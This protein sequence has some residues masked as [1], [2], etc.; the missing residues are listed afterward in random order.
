MKKTGNRLL[1]VLSM[2]LMIVSMIGAS[3]VQSS[4]GRVSVSDVKWINSE[5]KAMTGILLKPDTATAQSPAP[6]I[7]CCHGFLN[8]KE[9][10][11]IN[12]VE[13]ARRGYVVLACDMPSHGNSDIG[14][15]PG[16]MLNSV[17]EAVEFLC[18]INYVDD[19]RIGVTG[20]SFG[21]FSCHMAALLDG[22][23]DGKQHIAAILFNSMD[24]VYVDQTTGL[25]ANLYGSRNVGIIA[26]LYDEFAFNIVDDN[27]AAQPKPDYIHS[28]SAQ[29]FL[30]FGEE[31][32]ALPEREHDTV[33]TQE[34]D[35]VSCMRVIYTPDIT[36]PWSHFCARSLKATISFF[37]QALPAPNPISETSQ[38]W[39]W[40]V[41]FNVL[42]LVGMALFI[43]CGTIAF[44]HT[45]AFACLRAEEEPKPVVLTNGKSKVWFWAQLVICCVWG[46]ASYLT[47]LKLAQ[48]ANYS[49]SM[50]GM[51]AIRGI[52][53]WSIGCALVAI[54][55]MFIGRSV[56][57]G[58]SE[59]TACLKLS[60]Q[61]LWKTVTLAVVMA[62][63]T[64]LWVFAAYYLFKVDFRIWTLAAK[65]FNS[66]IFV[67]AIPFM[68]LLCVFY[69]T[70]S[71]ATNCFNYVDFGGKKWLN[72]I[73]LAIFNVLPAVIILVLQYTYYRNTGYL[74][75]SA[76]EAGLFIVWLYPFLAILPVSLIISRKIFQATRN[77]YLPGIINA[78]IVAL[79]SCANTCTFM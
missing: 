35:G 61:K 55:C 65:P 33:Y 24:P 74:R 73:V 26:G 56:N 52:S 27:G 6:A 3:L 38:V 1:L 75:W 72:T 29:S 9:M 41:V 45:P 23:T 60:A 58:W 62:A 12:F 2:A 59:L 17:H 21:S 47:A 5:G 53:L 44:V 32:G 39:Q 77:P 54:A 28:G 37:Q 18:G 30:Y 69:V 22:M 10:Q 8:N 67:L 57:G 19:A 49:P 15:D 34:V 50:L 16:A 71:V 78:I 40:K 70:N 51:P 20:H 36:H 66:R 63:L 68:F 79:M 14:T 64:F 4:G 42:G 31:P 76:D 46:A 13:L 48:S 43:V 7:V 25:Y 11:D